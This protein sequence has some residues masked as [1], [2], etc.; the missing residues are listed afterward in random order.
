VCLKFGLV[1]RNRQAFA[2]LAN[3]KGAAII[4]EIIAAPLSL[5]GFQF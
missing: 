3:D 1:T 5:L 4:Y 2:Q